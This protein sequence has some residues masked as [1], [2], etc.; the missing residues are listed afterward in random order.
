MTNIASESRSANIVRDHAMILL[1][2]SESQ[3]GWNFRKAHQTARLS[4]PCIWRRSTEPPQTR[5]EQLAMNMRCTPKPIVNAHPP[6]QRPQL[7]MDLRPASRGVGFPAPVATKPSAM[8][9]HKGLW[10]DDHHGHED[11]GKP[12]I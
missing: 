1:E 10:P 2:P 12:T 6:D 11:R 4:W 7:R 5:A 3:A 9:A 8:P